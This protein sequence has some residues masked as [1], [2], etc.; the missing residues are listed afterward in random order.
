MIADRVVLLPGAKIGRL[1]LMGSG[2][3]AMRDKEYKEGSIWLGTGT[4][5]KSLEIQ[6]LIH[7]P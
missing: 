7:H 3:L 6:Y 2:A 1:A 5:S 4:F